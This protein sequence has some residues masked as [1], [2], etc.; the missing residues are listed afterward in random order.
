MKMVPDYAAVETVTHVTEACGTLCQVVGSMPNIEV[1]KEIII[2]IKMYINHSIN[3]FF[4]FFLKI[5]VKFD[6]N[7]KN[8]IVKP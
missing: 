4:L 6:H 8:N 5:R 3:L 1:L 2:K 7:L